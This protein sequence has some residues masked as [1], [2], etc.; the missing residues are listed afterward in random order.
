MR[1]KLEAVPYITT[2]AKKVS[3]MSI[4]SHPIQSSPIMYF[5]WLH[6]QSAKTETDCQQYCLAQRD[7]VLAT[8]LCFQLA[9]LPYFQQSNLLAP[10][11][12][13]QGQQQKLHS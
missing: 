11:T 2:R 12:T 4:K 1:Y 13:T 9:R 6:V 3:T 5:C 8:V 7:M 10:H